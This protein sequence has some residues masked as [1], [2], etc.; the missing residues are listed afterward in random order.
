[1]RWQA[2]GG[3][4]ALGR[5]L[6]GAAPL[7]EEG[8]PRTAA[9]LAEGS[10]LLCE[11]GAERRRLIEMERELRPVRA[12]L[13]GLLLVAILAMGPYLGFW[14]LGPLAGAAAG[15]VVGDLLAGRS[16][17]PE[18][19]L[20]AA[21]CFSQLM[22]AL[23]AL[24]TGGPNSLFLSWLAIPAATL[25]TRFNRR[26]A[27]FGVGFSAVLLAAVSFADKPGVA[28]RHPELFVAPATVLLGVTLLSTAMM[29]SEV[30]HRFQ[31]VI[32][33]LTNLFNRQAFLQRAP[34]LLARQGLGEPI[35]LLLGDIDH[36][37][38]VNDS[39]GH[40]VGDAVLQE[41]A[42]VLRSSLRAFD[43]VYR[44]GGEELIVLLPAGLEEAVASAERLRA[45]VA[46]ARPAGLELTISFG[47]AC[48]KPGEALEQLIARADRALYVAK[49]GGRNRVCALP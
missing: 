4:P 45:A 47:V 43:Q 38:A 27:L 40:L 15:F 14:P 19:P 29:H 8:A 31:A 25:T 9:R 20:M 39:H 21:W 17:R 1:M 33:P 24:L 32:D 44:Y 35:S 42:T 12:A 37:K 10:S 46:A 23:S 49:T 16:A 5:L 7:P 26:G 48:A 11:N 22:I 30:K 41:V 2:L 13:F 6:A 28:Y 34:E 18:Y 36:F 3:A